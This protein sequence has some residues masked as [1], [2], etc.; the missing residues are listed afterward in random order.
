MKKLFY[1]GICL[2]GIVP[3][4]CSG[5]EP[6]PALP[7]PELTLSPDAPIAFT[8]AGG[9]VA[10]AI[11]TNLESWTAQS[12]RTWCKVS[13]EEDRLIVSAEANAAAEPMPAAA[14]TVTATD[15]TRTLC[16]TLQAT[17]E[18]GEAS[19][20]DL[21]SGGTANCYLITSG[22]DYRFD[23]TVRG[24]GATTEGLEAPAPL[25]GTA[26]ALVWQTAPDMISGLSL[27][28]GQIRFTI[29][30]Q[31][32]SALI[33]V[34]NDAGEILWSWHIWYPRTEVAGIG[35]KTGYDVMNLNLGALTADAGN[36]ES[37]GMLYQWGR[38]DPLPASPTPT[39]D[40]S[41]VGAPLYDTAGNE[42]KIANSPWSD[43][44]AN[45][46]EYAIAHPTVCLSNY[47][48]YGTSHDWLKAG[49]GNDALWGNP[50]GYE[51]DDEN[52]LPNK[53]A[54][55]FYDPCPV[56]WRVPP[57]DVFRTFTS[58][59]GY[60]WTI[61]DFDLYDT[62][63]DGMLSLGDYACGWIFNVGEST[64]SYFPAAARYDGSYA[65]LMGSMSGLWGNYWGNCPYESSMFDGA[66][67]AVLSFQIKDMYGNE[68]ITVSPA[69]AGSRADAYSVRCIR[70]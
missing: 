63:G 69:A 3:A 18:A 27:D 61:D 58:S 1:V 14:V 50:K 62:N 11:E 55:S 10:I 38:K 59:G 52:L 39:G 21:S 5:D 67:Y 40:T 8:A 2:L 33:A 28:E 42:V 19:A 60:S 17:Q 32:G 56:G 29:A 15:G 54:K 23:A 45:T 30:D 49:S 48:Q 25:S 20:V 44:E 31:P 41:T 7:D 43:T 36:V 66:A 64:P 68:M 46:L 47:A 65:M 57:A 16:R 51:K 26:A 35:S 22:G 34:C 37:Y 53:G 4:G 12:D 24:N 9:S 70:E 6:E 13:R